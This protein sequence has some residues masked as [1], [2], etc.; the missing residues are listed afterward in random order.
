MS[1]RDRRLRAGAPPALFQSTGAPPWD[2]RSSH[3]LDRVAGYPESP[4]AARDLDGMGDRIELSDDRRRRHSLQSLVAIGCDI[5]AGE[6]G[7]RA[8]RYGAAHNRVD[9]RLF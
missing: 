9:A 7:E 3:Q 5:E 6:L 8:V 2:W 4:L 1:A